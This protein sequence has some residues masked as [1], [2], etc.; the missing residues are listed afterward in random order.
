MGNSICSSSSSQKRSP[1]KCQAS[2]QQDAVGN[3]KAVFLL[4]LLFYNIYVGSF[5]LQYRRDVIGMTACFTPLLHHWAHFCEKP[6]K[7]QNRNANVVSKCCRWDTR[8][9]AFLNELVYNMPCV[10][11]M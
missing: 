7:K 9:S 3:N 4:A 11:H 1:D 10:Q 2:R 8:R 6:K 5:C